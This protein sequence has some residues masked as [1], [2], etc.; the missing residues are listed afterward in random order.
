MR[1]AFVALSILFASFWA[2][3]LAA[4]DSNWTILGPGEMPAYQRGL[5]LQ[6][7][8][9]IYVE[10]LGIP[11]TRFYSLRFTLVD[12]RSMRPVAEVPLQS[13]KH[14]DLQRIQLEDYGIEV[15]PYVDYRWYVSLNPN[16]DFLLSKE[17]TRERAKLAQGEIMRIAPK[18]LLAYGTPC[19]KSDVRW[20]ADAG[21]W[22]DAFACISDLIEAGP[23]DRTFGY[24]RDELLWSE[25]S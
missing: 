22:Y 1:T 12:S 10:V 5:T 7:S 14:P 2:T 3:S 17:T 13:Q 18:S 20:L 19:E 25:V 16:S 8:P 9:T 24:L 21:I 11:W 15:E 4:F 23:G 6:K